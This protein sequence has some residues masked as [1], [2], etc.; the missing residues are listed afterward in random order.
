MERK[1]SHTKYEAKRNTNGV[2]EIIHRFYED[3]NNSRCAAGKKECITRNKIKK[4]K[5]Y[6]LDSLKNLHHK[7]LKTNSMTIGYSSFL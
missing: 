2:E 7:F 6:L 4:Q 3:D 1:A 5:R